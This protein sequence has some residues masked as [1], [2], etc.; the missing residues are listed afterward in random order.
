MK[1]IWVKKT[2]YRCYLVDDELVD[3]AKSLL[4]YEPEGC[5]LLGDLLD[6]NVSIDYDNEEVFKPIQFEVKDDQRA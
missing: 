6:M 2:I 4:M 5:E 1:E 3:H